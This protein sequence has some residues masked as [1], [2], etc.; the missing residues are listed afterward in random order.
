MPQYTPP[1][2]LTIARQLHVPL[3]EEVALCADVTPGWLV[4]M[5]KNPLHARRIRVAELR[6]ALEQEEFALSLESMLPK[7]V[8]LS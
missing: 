5:A 4:K 6:A 2:P 7:G 3:K 8:R 1:A